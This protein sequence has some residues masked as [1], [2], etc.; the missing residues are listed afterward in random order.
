MCQ[1]WPFCADSYAKREPGRVF[2]CC[3]FFGC[4]IFCYNAWGNIRSDH[5]L[6]SKDAAGEVWQTRFAVYSVDDPDWLPSVGHPRT[7]VGV[8]IDLYLRVS[9][10]MDFLVPLSLEVRLSGSQQKKM[11]AATVLHIPL[12]PCF[13]ERLL[14]SEVFRGACLGSGTIMYL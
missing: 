13:L 1:V 7:V 4:S 5:S 8:C 9:V 14:L 10:R 3:K 12:V 2:F 11:P 6:L